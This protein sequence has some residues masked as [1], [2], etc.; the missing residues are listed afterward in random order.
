MY[1]LWRFDQL[2]ATIGAVVAIVVLGAIARAAF[3][4]MG[5]EER[6]TRGKDAS[7]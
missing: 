6:R 3:G 1:A 7:F 2:F 4:D 5:R